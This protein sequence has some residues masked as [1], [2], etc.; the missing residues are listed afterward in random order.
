MKMNSLKMIIIIKRIT[1]EI[2][3]YENSAFDL[4]K[5]SIMDIQNGWEELRL[6]G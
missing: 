1:L 2:N 5:Y 4:K 6:S 3:V